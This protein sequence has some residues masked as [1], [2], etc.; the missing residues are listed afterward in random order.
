MKQKIFFWLDADINFFCLSYYLQ[1]ICNAEFYAIIDITNKPKK[2][3]KEQKLVRFKKTWFYHDHISTHKSPDLDHLADIEQ[4]YN[5]NLWELSLNERI[6]YKHN[7][8][9]K[10]TSIEILSILEGQYFFLTRIAN[11]D[12]TPA[13]LSGI[14]GVCANLINNNH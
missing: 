3:F 6:F 9:Y 11:N 14:F 7:K 1:K 5:L 13:D 8:F 12:L 4:K 10:F 2:F